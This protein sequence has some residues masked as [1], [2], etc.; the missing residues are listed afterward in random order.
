[1]HIVST[2]FQLLCEIEWEFRPHC[3]AR[4]YSMYQEY[5]TFLSCDV[6]VVAVSTATDNVH[7]AITIIVYATTCVL[8]VAKI[9]FTIV[10]S[11]TDL[12]I[13]TFIAASTAVDV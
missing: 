10:L 2:I 13:D 3:R 7:E 12:T 11:E 1:M 8:S 4:T 9:T 5:R 6:V